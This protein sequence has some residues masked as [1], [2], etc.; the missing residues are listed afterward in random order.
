[1]RLK[2]LNYKRLNYTGLFLL[3]ISSLFY[4]GNNLDESNFS[5]FIMIIWSMAFLS[6]AV[7]FLIVVNLSIVLSKFR[8]QSTYPN[9]FITNLTIF[10]ISLFLLFLWTYESCFYFTNNTC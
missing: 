6:F 1:M 7:I 10:A 8:I 3:L 5:D 2:M 4:F 9:N